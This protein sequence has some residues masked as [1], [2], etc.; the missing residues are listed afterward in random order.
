MVKRYLAAHETMTKTQLKECIM[1]IAVANAGERVPL[2]A[3]EIAEKRE[4]NTEKEVKLVARVVAALAGITA[5]APAGADAS[6]RRESVVLKELIFGGGESEEE[7]NT[8]ANV[9][10]NSEA[11]LEQIEEALPVVTLEDVFGNY[12][13]LD[14]PNMQ[15][16]TKH[17][18]RERLV[19]DL[20]AAALQTGSS[21]EAAARTFKDLSGN[22]AYRVPSDAETRAKNESFTN[23][24][25][26]DPEE[27]VMPRIP[28]SRAP[29]DIREWNQ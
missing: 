15:K 5:F 17:V 3:E 13:Q 25:F 20:S 10:L 18:A 9:D 28:A 27:P 22:F 1:G 23:N 21:S 2:T 4:I 26:I 11:V 14:A 24:D 19:T 7:T 29:N 16:S 8:F 6:G 12:R